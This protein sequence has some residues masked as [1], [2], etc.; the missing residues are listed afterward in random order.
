MNITTDIRQRVASASPQLKAVVAAAVGVIVLAA[1]VVAISIQNSVGSP[2]SSRASSGVN[3]GEATTGSS[4][5]A[6]SASPSTGGVYGKFQVD[7]TGMVVM[8]RTTDPV[9][10]AAAA[11]EIMTSVDTRAYNNAYIYR[12]EAIRRMVRPSPD[13]VGPGSKVMLDTLATVAPYV[14]GSG[15]APETGKYVDP[16]RGLISLIDTYY[17]DPPLPYMQGPWTLAF[18]A[19]FDE[20]KKVNTVWKETA[21]N[22]VDQ[23]TF[24]KMN[25]TSPFAYGLTLLKFGSDQTP[26]KPGES[27]GMYWVQVRIDMGEEGRIFES[28]LV[29]MGVKIWCDAPDDGGLC[30]VAS[31]Y[32]VTTGNMVWPLLR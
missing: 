24:E 4:S 27:F 23:A 30:E 18:P 1:V 15:K 2:G 8:P 22:V 21:V 16:E 17:P 5:S 14:P 29:T 3:T 32:P 31:V 6:A 13:Y 10:A 19:R 28:A 12:D 26:D 20:M 25:P 9:T 11:A 7:S